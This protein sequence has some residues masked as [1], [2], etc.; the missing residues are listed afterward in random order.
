MS[1]NLPLA[2]GNNQFA[3]SIRTQRVHVQWSYAVVILLKYAWWIKPL[4]NRYNAMKWYCTAH[5]T[6]TIKI[7][8]HLN[9]KSQHMSYAALDLKPLWYLPIVLWRPMTAG[10]TTWVNT[11]HVANHESNIS[12]GIDSI[13]NGVCILLPLGIG[14]ILN[15]ETGSLS[16]H[17]TD[18]FSGCHFFLTA[19]TTVLFI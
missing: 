6:I 18:L 14:K 19:S 16:S 12:T 11:F 9:L 2:I 15:H 3:V 8:F 13:G 5:N 17:G 7:D 1:E 10:D 4:F